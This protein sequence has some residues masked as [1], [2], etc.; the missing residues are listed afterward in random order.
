M[1][2]V[3]CSP[4]TDPTGLIPS[5]FPTPAEMTMETEVKGEAL[6]RIR[7]STEYKLA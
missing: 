7:V 1:G 4:F 3:V 5:P 6:Y 2:R